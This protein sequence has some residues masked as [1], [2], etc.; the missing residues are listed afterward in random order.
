MF[1]INR[2]SGYDWLLAQL[3]PR[4]FFFRGSSRT[5]P[6]RG[7]RSSSLLGVSTRVSG[8]AVDTRVKVGRQTTT[9]HKK[10]LWTRSQRLE[11]GRAE[12]TQSREG[13]KRKKQ[14]EIDK[15][16]LTSWPPFLLQL[17]THFASSRPHF[18]CLLAF[19]FHGH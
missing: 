10:G 5:R 12:K 3:A 18:L 19:R 11:G 13:R 7:V 17:N 8:N 4:V 6:L 15:V 9:T 1:E 2:T 16:Q 14:A